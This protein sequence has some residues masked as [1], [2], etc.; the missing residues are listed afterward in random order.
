MKTITKSKLLCT[1]DTLDLHESANFSTDNSL[2]YLAKILAK[3]KK[4]KLVDI[5]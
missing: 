2:K 1:L 5:T 3:A 4:L